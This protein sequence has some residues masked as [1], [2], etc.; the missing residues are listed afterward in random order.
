VPIGKHA[1][2]DRFIERFKRRGGCVRFVGHGAVFTLR[3]ILAPRQP[4]LA[5]IEHAGPAPR[6]FCWR[7]RTRP[8]VGAVP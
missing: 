7:V 2:A 8:S 4:I 3:P 1:P 5:E 6:S